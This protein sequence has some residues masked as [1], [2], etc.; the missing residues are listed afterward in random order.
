MERDRM[1]ATEFDVLFGSDDF[2]E[3]VET[4]SVSDTEEIWLPLA[5]IEHDGYEVSSHGRVRHS[6]NRLIRKL[7]ALKGGY[8]P[9]PAF[10][11]RSQVTGKATAFC[12]HRAVAIAHLN[13]GR[14]IPVGYDVDHVD[15]DHDNNHVSNLRIIPMSENRSRNRKGLPA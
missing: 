10:S 14:P 9:Y 2:T 7:T 12:V 6:K 1:S 3:V 11:Y 5:G 13:G 8:E 4:E 15:M